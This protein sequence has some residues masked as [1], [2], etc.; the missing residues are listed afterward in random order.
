MENPLQKLIDQQ[1][2][3]KTGDAN[4]RGRLVEVTET[5]VCLMARTGWREIMIDRVVSIKKQPES[6]ADGQG[7]AD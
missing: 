4:Y 1:V 5:A 3:V 7:T 6:P 2:V